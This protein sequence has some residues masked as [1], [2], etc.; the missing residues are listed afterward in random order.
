MLGSNR[1]EGASKHMQSA[2]IQ[3]IRSCFHISESGEIK[4]SREKCVS[5]GTEPQHLSF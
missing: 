3:F 4:A 5:L 1:E 2:F